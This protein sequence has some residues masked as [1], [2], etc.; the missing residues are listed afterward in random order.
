MFFTQI[1]G[2]LYPA[3]IFYVL[4]L[5]RVIPTSLSCVRP[6]LTKLLLTVI[7]LLLAFI[8]SGEMQ[9]EGVSCSMLPTTSIIHHASLKLLLIAVTLKQGP[10][11]LGLF[12]RPPS[13]ARD[14]LELEQLL[15]L[16]LLLLLYTFHS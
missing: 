11:Y 5:H 10:L 12:Y 3:S 1:V 8:L 6:G 4:M 2:V 15:L 16:L 9:K 14:V 13:A 7:F